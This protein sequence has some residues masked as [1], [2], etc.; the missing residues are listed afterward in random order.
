MDAE[1]LPRAPSVRPAGRL[2]NAVWFLSIPLPVLLPRFLHARLLT[3]VAT[4]PDVLGD[5]SGGTGPHQRVVVLLGRT[6]LLG[7][8]RGSELGGQNG[9]NLLDRS[10]S[11]H[12][13]IRE[14]NVLIAEAISS[15]GLVLFAIKR[16]LLT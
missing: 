4:C 9:W 6:F 14:T 8:C 15:E 5:L 11:G 2:P 13:L 12:H 16:I 1:T 10:T 7:P 3:T